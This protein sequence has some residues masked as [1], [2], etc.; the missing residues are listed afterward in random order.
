MNNLTEIGPA[1]VEMAHRIVW[2][3][4][5]TVDA[6]GRP[7]YGPEPVGYDLRAVV[8]AASVPDSATGSVV[9][10][11]PAPAMISGALAPFSAAA[12]TSAGPR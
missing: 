6:R 3:S 5:A 7:R 12:A 11:A 10:P 8:P 2:C 9:S 1:F 4:A